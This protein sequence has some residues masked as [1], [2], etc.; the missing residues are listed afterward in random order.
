VAPVFSKR[1]ISQKGLSGV[2]PLVLV[3]PGHTYVVKQLTIYANPNFPLTA[4][5]EDHAAGDLAAYGVA[6]T[7]GAAGWY[8]FYGALVFEQGASFRW[9]V[10][11]GL[12]DGADVTASG[13]DLTN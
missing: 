12:G 3:P 8:G 1:F 9:A 6:F 10:N 11:A 5:F 4:F 13:Y 2:T 7:G